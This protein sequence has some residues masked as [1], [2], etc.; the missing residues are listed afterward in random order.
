MLFNKIKDMHIVRYVDNYVT[1]SKS[2]THG[3]G[4][5]K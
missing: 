4:V 1:A 5:A 2:L 3:T